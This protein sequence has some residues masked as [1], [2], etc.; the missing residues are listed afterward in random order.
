[1][2]RLG[3]P[4]PAYGVFGLTRCYE[5]EYMNLYNLRN[6]FPKLKL[7]QFSPSKLYATIRY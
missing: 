1:M 4:I 2:D 7:Q 6:T 3:F 5:Y